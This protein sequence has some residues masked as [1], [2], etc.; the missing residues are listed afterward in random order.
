MP[1]IYKDLRTIYPKRQPNRHCSKQAFR[2]RFTLLRKHA[3][4]HLVNTK[5][6]E[7]RVKRGSNK[8]R[9]R[10]LSFHDVSDEVSAYIPSSLGSGRNCAFGMGIGLG[11]G[12][13][14]LR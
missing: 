11:W 1:S 4:S 6:R 2:T 8:H 7:D 14:C 5:P 3:C 10:A 12:I 13:L 9:K